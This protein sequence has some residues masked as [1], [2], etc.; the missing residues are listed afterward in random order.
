MDAEMTAA[1]LLDMIEWLNSADPNE[2]RKAMD[3]TEKEIFRDG[4]IECSTMAN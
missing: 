1:E 4:A 2:I 3:D